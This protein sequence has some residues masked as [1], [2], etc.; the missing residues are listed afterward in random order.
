MQTEDTN[1]KNATDT[2]SKSATISDTPPFVCP[3]DGCFAAFGTTDA[4]DDHEAS[5]HNEGGA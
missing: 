5:D 4:R 3:Y 1:P 2:D